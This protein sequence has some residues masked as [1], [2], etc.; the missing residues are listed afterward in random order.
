[1]PGIDPSQARQTNRNFEPSPNAQTGNPYACTSSWQ[2]LMW[3]F[4]TTTVIR[5]APF[6][7]LSAAMALVGLSRVL[8]SR[9]DVCMK[10]RDGW[11]ML[12]SGAWELRSV[13]SVVVYCSKLTLSFVSFAPVPVEVGNPPNEQYS[14][15]N[16]CLCYCGV[17][18]Y[19]Y[20]I[21]GPQTLF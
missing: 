3:F 1:M 19:N 20:S 2:M 5:M 13:H 17:P 15:L 7:D 21:A 11:R 10:L 8:W 4:S 14:G 12:D 16:N 9:R 18:Y 6:L